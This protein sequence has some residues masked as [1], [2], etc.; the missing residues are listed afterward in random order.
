MIYEWKV[1][2]QIKTAP[3]KAAEV[4]NKLAEENRLN[5]E[6][7]V[8]ASRPEDAPL[9]NEFEWRDDVAAEEYRKHQARHII[10]CLIQREEEKNTEPV[11]AYFKVSETTN[12]Y[13]PINAIIKT[14][15]GQEALKRLCLK[16]FMAFKA[17]YANILKFIKANEQVDALQTVIEEA[18][19]L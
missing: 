16:E 19:A 4:L 17:K 11:K 8:N 13:E 15:D 3:E 10:A 7:V 6:E 14:E 9:H 12:N 2:A 5:A 18:L 1:G